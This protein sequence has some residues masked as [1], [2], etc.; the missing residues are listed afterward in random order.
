MPIILDLENVRQKRENSLLQVRTNPPSPQCF[1]AGL[2]NPNPSKG[3]R[4]RLM[5]CPNL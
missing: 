1:S 4:S 3:S 2:N 5:V